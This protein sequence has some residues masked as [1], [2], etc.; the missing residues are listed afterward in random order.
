ML[1]GSGAHRL[2]QSLGLG[3]LLRAGQVLGTATVG[4]RLSQVTV[5]YGTAYMTLD[6]AFLAKLRSLEVSGAPFGSGWYYSRSPLAFAFTGLH[7]VAALDLSAGAIES[8]DGLRLTQAGG[9]GLNE[10][11]LLGISMDLR[12]KSAIADIRAQPSGFGE[13]AAFAALQIPVVHLNPFTGVISIPNSPATVSPSLASL[14]NQTFAESRRLPPVFAAGEPLGQ[15]AFMA[16][17]HGR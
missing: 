10:V 16:G 11:A 1:T 17:T 15:I 14:L 6:E 2:D 12:S 8:A 9:E 3:R 5:T 13:T 7:G 4:A